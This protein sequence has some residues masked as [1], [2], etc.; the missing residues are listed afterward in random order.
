[1]RG[2]QSEAATYEI[3]MDDSCRVHIFKPALRGSLR[4][5]SKVDVDKVTIPRS[6]IGNTE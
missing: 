5:A 6:G 2:R 3:A 1:M 4:T